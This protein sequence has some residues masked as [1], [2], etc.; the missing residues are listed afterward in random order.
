MNKQKQ[1]CKIQ[2]NPLGMSAQKYLSK[3]KKLKIAQTSRIVTNHDCIFSQTPMRFKKQQVQNLNL[4]FSFCGTFE[5]FPGHPQRGI[6]L[7]SALRRTWG[8]QGSLKY[9]FTSEQQVWSNQM[10]NKNEEDEKIKLLIIIKEIWWWK[11]L[12]FYLTS[13]GSK[14]HDLHM[15][16][17][18]NETIGHFPETVCFK[19][20]PQLKSP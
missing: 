7:L 14:A 8:Q 20:K 16:P 5:K 19:R 9:W 2:V 17:S 11:S 6:N 4:T 3:L 12:I 13:E 18:H 10:E 15:F 1:H